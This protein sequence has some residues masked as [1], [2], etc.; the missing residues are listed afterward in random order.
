MR[1]VSEYL[2]EAR[3]YEQRAK[4]PRTPKQESSSLISPQHSVAWRRRANERL[5][6]ARYRRQRLSIVEEKKMQGRSVLIGAMLLTLGT[7]WLAGLGQRDPAKVASVL[8]PAT[9]RTPPAPAVVPSRV[10]TRPIPE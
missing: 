2:A 6:E 1:T 9:Q 5:R 4:K 7:L 3:E 8:S 10:P